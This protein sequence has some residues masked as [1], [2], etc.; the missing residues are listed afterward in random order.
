MMGEQNYDFKSLISG[1]GMAV[2]LGY[3]VIYGEL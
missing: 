1:L 3:N 2:W